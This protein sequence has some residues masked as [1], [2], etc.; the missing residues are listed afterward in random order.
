MLRPSV[1]DLLVGVADGLAATV[2]PELPPGP[3][4][5]QVRFAVGITRKVARA[6]PRLTPYLV[7]D[8]ADL[9]STLRRLRAVQAAPLARVSDDVAT[10]QALA[11]AEALPLEP[12]P[13][14]D[15]LAA[16]NLRLRE[17]L[18]ELCERTVLDGECEQEVR[19]LLGRM[20]AREVALG[21]SPWE[22]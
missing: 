5:D 18:T 13:T 2:L 15:E 11:A 10:R 9:A 20:T 6:L 1:A 21:L 16:V 19:A 7:Q 4:R 12:L 17:A 22:R 3:A 14:L 8:T